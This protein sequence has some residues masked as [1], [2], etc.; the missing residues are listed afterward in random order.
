MPSH[1][2][3]CP[4]SLGK[5]AI[6]KI[7]GKCRDHTSIK[8]IKL[9]FSQIRIDEVKNLHQNIDTKKTLVKNDNLKQCTKNA[10]FFLQSTP[11]INSMIQFFFR[12]FLTN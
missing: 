3:K 5:N 1:G 9:R 11:V 2:Y 7:I 12:Y 8:L 4:D 6:L 10:E